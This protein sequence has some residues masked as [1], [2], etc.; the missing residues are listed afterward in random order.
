MKIIRGFNFKPDDHYGYPEINDN[1]M[2]DSFVLGLSLDDLLE[3]YALG[4]CTAFAMEGGNPD[5]MTDVFLGYG[6]YDLYGYGYMCISDLDDETF[7]ELIRDGLDL[8]NDTLILD[9]AI[10]GCNEA[11]MKEL[12]EDKEVDIIFAFPSSWNDNQE[13]MIYQN[14]NRINKDVLS[15]EYS[16]VLAEDI[17]PKMA[18]IILGNFKNPSGRILAGKIYNPISKI[19][20]NIDDLLSQ[21]L[22]PEEMSSLKNIGKGTNMMGRFGRG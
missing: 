22:T 10:K 11:F 1:E 13:F 9:G 18:D 19:F 7:G 17:L 12:S 20:P 5:D 21:S 16:S 2:M 8:I 15:S 3:F 14:G 4:D 6:N